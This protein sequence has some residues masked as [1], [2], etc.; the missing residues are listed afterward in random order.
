MKRSILA[1]VVLGTV[2]LLACAGEKTVVSLRDFCKTELKS[3]GLQVDRSTTFHVKA[4]G[5]GG[6]KGWTY[7]SDRMFAYGWIIDAETRDLVWKMSVRNTER[8]GDDR[9]FDGDVTLGR[10]SYEL[11]FTVYGFEFHSTFK[12]MVINIDHRTEHLFGGGF[13][14]TES[15][16]FQW[17]SQWWSDDMDDDWRER[18]RNWGI[19]LRVDEESRGTV[20]TFTAPKRDAKSLFRAVALGDGE[21][22]REG[23][24]LSDRTTLNVYALGEG[25]K[26]SDFVDY[27]WIV[28]R[29]TRERVWEMK[30]S[31][32]RHAGGAKKN[33]RYNRSVTLDAGDYVLYYITD[34]SHS[35]ADWNDQ[36]PYDPLNWGI[37]LSARSTDDREAFRPT[38][39]KEIDNVIVSLIGVGDDDYRSEG[40]TLKR[41]TKV[42]VYAI[43]ERGYSRRKMADYGTILDARTRKKVW[44]M[45][46]D[47]TYHAGGA[48]KNR[49]FDGVIHLRAG[50]Y[51]AAYTS[52]D[53][54][55]W[56][57]W[58][59]EKPFDAEHYG[60]T[61]MG[62]GKDFD[63]AVVSKFVEE[64]D[65]GVL[66]ELVRV[67]DSANLRERFS[68]DRTTRVRIHA[69]GEG[70]NRQMYDYGWIED[71]ETGAVVWEMTY[72]MTF[73]AGGGRK[74]RTVNTTL[75]LEKG[76]YTLRYRS[77]DS[78]SYGRWNV[79][80]PEDSEYWGITLYRDEPMEPAPPAPAAPPA[81]SSPRGS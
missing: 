15:K 71:A 77:D 21:V 1:I 14:K 2:H 63:P 74:N 31:N 27:G 36:P 54:H 17:F 5:G 38:S 75:I 37:T 34:D 26:K 46:G 51:I 43:G 16:F 18:C 40:F 33:I 4:L 41:D 48:S 28:D 58:N 79:H 6:S 29:W 67:R 66:A 7:K 53:S 52:D 23:F 64:R 25:Q 11:Y 10:G 69:I 24:S 68:L 49:C 65:R 55:S 81:P 45:D 42:R 57:E 47:E 62:A 32:V 22:V 61:V 3:V 60:M 30:P 59:A 56:E 12:H 35:A 73:H 39:Y 20:K 13:G 72:A 70:V 80:E 9:V 44:V 76:D 78:H 8:D 50:S 19:E